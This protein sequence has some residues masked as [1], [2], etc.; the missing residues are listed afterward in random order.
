MGCIGV[1][2]DLIWSSGHKQLYGV[3]LRAA[4]ANPMHWKDIK[5]IFNENLDR[6]LKE[7]GWS[8]RKLSLKITSN[9]F[10]ISKLINGDGSLG[11]DKV[12]DISAALEIHYSEL[13]ESELSRASRPSPIDD[14]A[15]FEDLVISVR[16]YTNATAM[17]RNRQIGPRD[18]INV[19]K[20]KEGEINR[21]VEIL[22]FVDIY[23]FIPEYPFLKLDRMGE[24]SLSSQVLNGPKRD[25]YEKELDGPLAEKL[26]AASARYSSVIETD[27]IIFTDEVI[28]TDLLSDRSL[29]LKYECYLLPGRIN[30]KPEKVLTFAD[31]NE[32]KLVKRR[33]NDREE[34]T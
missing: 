14:D 25:E 26:A 34:I 27:D 32:V 5:P 20:Q 12:L 17:I 29:V 9:E 31:P 4:L 19:W 18:I 11:F 8:R 6:I 2:L 1:W 16:R 30:G 23:S 13:F 24:Q 22:D 7:K 15:M 3:I 21:L 33:E 28:R 10:Y